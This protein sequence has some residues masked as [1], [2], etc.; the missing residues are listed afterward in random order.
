ML[1]LVFLKY[2][3][4]A[5]EA[6]QD[7][8]RELFQTESD[9]LY[10]LPREDYDNDAEYQAALEEELEVLDYYR[11]ANVFWVPRAARWSTLKEKAALP[12]G[13]GS[14]VPPFGFS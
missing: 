10:H 6:R 9:D 1:G 2:V 7:E 8:L 13:S 3:S 5:F 4:D 14:A 12:I 11:E